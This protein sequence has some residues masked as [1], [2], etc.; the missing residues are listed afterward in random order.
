M[1]TQAGHQNTNIP[2]TYHGTRRSLPCVRIDVYSR[3]FI[4]HSTI[5]WRGAGTGGY[6]FEGNYHHFPRFKLIDLARNISHTKPGLLD[7]KLTGFVKDQCGH[8]CN[9]N[10]IVKEYGITGEIAP[11]E[12]SYNYK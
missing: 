5:D 8:R 7:V 10:V 6:V 12:E 1:M 2:I 11:R 4:L 3:Q 9:E